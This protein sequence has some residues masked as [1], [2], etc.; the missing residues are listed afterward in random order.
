MRLPF[1]SPR[2]L[3][4]VALLTTGCAEDDPESSASSGTGADAAPP[5]GVWL[6]MDGGIDKN[7]CGTDDVYRDADTQ[8]VLT[9]NGDGTFTVDQGAQE[10]FTCTIDGP[11]FDCPNRLF[12][13]E[14]VDMLDATVSW[15]VSLSGT[16]HSDTYM[17]GTQRADID[18]AG[19][20][21]NLVSTAL[22]IALP[23]YY[24]VKF[25]AEKQ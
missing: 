3:A 13:E 15:Q 7:N 18:C 8:F 1:R 21:C 17:T 25:T 19:T 6:Y 22:A 16:F 2:S 10:D 9:D 14:P 11:D 23:C 4:I 20:Q 5:S 12:A 24:T